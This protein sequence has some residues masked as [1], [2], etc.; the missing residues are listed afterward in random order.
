MK[1][2]SIISINNIKILNL[3]GKIKTSNACQKIIHARI[4]A[5]IIPKKPLKKP[6]PLLL[7]QQQ[8]F[9]VHHHYNICN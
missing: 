7:L 1:N 8:L 6:P 2:K 4:N 5:N 9:I 3:I